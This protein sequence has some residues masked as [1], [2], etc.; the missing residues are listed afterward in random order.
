VSYCVFIPTRARY[1][2]VERIIPKWNEQV[3][4]P[5]LYL[6]VERWERGR[7]SGIARKFDN[8][9]VLVLGKSNKGINYARRWIVQEAARSN[10]KKIIQADDDLFPHPSTDVRKLFDFDGL[11]T[12]GLGVMMPYYGLMFGNDTIKAADRPLMSKGALGKR[13]FSLNVQD[14]I[15]IG[16]FDARLHSGWG[17][18][19]LVRD[20]MAQKQYTWYVQAAV[21]GVSI[22]NRFTPGGINHFHQEDVTSRLAGQEVSHNII[23]KKWGAEFVSTPG[24]AMRFQWKKFMNKFVPDW[25]TRIDW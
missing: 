9:E 15:D 25:E 6:V 12:L 3:E 19:E 1:D 20:G 4:K 10:L 2:L 13:L 14:V 17:D 24:G 21:K 18:D 5:E 7:Y 11:P 23:Y 8:V 16:N 22:A